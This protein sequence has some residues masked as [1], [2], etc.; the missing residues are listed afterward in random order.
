MIANLAGQQLEAGWLNL[1]SFMGVLSINLGIINLF[2]IPI[3]DGG[4]LVFFS[5]EAMRNKPISLK[6][7]EILQQ[8]GI[9]LLGTL[10]VF[11]IYN[12]FARLFAN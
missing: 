3:L 1:W 7:Q 2:P 5:I 8:V 11:V 4:H 6:S 12:D 9:V 10:M